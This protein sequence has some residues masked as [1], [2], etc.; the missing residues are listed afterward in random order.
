MTSGSD[1]TIPA[2]RRDVKILYIPVEVSEKYADYN[3]KVE[4]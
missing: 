1:S 3:Y 2:F 4:V